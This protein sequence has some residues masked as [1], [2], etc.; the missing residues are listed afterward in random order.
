MN[1][2]Q[3]LLVSPSGR[4]VHLAKMITWRVIATAATII[5]SYLVTGD[6]LV[7]AT[8]GGFEATSKMALYY[9]HER[10]WARLIATTPV[11]STATSD[12]DSTIGT[13]DLAG[14]P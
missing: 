3:R 8:I 11:T 9:G 6:L 12:T 2:V 13:F 10:G 7:G 1:T 14:Q 4:R 5:I